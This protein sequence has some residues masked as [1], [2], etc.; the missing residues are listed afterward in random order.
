[1]INSEKDINQIAGNLISA[2]KGSPMISEDM[3]RAYQHGIISMRDKV[4]EYLS[5]K[6]IL[7]NG[8]VA[9]MLKALSNSIECI[10]DTELVKTYNQGIETAQDIIYKYIKAQDIIYK[11]LK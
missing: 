1:M 2:Y 9:E 5:N 10:S 3:F 4:N 11:Y 8:E 7:R 6:T